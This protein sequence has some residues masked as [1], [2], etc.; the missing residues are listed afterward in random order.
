MPF[1]RL[2]RRCCDKQKILADILI[3]YPENRS[4]LRVLYIV[5][6]VD[7]RPVLEVRFPPPAIHDHTKEAL[8][9]VR[10]SGAHLSATD[11]AMYPRR[12]C[13]C[14]EQCKEM[15]CGVSRTVF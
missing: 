11:Q 1:S 9:S 15:V 4:L 6:P 10:V 7:V 3:R 14:V 13:Q 12:L 2:D 5:L 8:P